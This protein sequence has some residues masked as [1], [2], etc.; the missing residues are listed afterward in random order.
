MGFEP[1]TSA[2][3]ESQPLCCSIPLADMSCDGCHD[4]VDEILAENPDDNPPVEHDHSDDCDGCRRHGL[5]KVQNT[6]MY[7]EGLPGVSEI[8][9][10][11]YVGQQIISIVP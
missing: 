1:T 8:R 11:V 9:E 6:A 10:R 7:Y 5:K 2:S 3:A 4:L